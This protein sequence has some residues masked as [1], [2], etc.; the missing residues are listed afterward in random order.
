MGHL[1]THTPRR[2]I[3]TG[4]VGLVTIAAYAAAGAMQTLVWNPLA[5]APGATLDE[6]YLALS[7]ANE[8]LGAPRVLAWAVI[9]VVLAALVLLLS[10][11]LPSMPPAVV[12]ATDLW[13]LVLAAPAHMFV[14][15]GAGMSLADTF[16]IGGGDHAP[17]GAVLYA[18]SA[19]A[20]LALIAL[21][22]RAP[23]LAP[24]PAA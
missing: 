9:G 8:S 10:V 18:L 4:L 24:F 21:A 15:F 13:L 1:G 16:G 14:A 19:V 5:A 20:L 23:T 6:I 3:L 12:L 7:L 22:V 11:V 2:S 17:W